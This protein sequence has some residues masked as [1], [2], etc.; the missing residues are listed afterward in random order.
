MLAHSQAR[1]LYRPSHFNHQTPTEYAARPPFPLAISCS[2]GQRSDRSSH[3]QQDNG[4]HRRSDPHAH[5]RLRI[6]R[7]LRLAQLP[8]HPLSKGELGWEEHS[9]VRTGGSGDAGDCGVDVQP[10]EGRSVGCVCGMLCF[11]G[12][13]IIRAGD[14]GW[15][16][17]VWKAK[18]GRTRRGYLED[19]WTAC[20]K[21]TYH[22]LKTLTH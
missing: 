7:H 19:S 12:D 20:G 14:L 15:D 1:V 22:R 21:A 17:F 18:E 2:S 13:G 5:Y 11:D 4:L 3:F 6:P 16:N 9:A 10:R 8:G